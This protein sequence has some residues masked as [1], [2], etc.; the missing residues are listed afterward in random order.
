[1]A[2]E[3][4]APV[5]AEPTANTQIPTRPAE[6]SAEPVVAEAKTLKEDAVIASEGVAEG[7]EHGA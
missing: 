1:M 3:S 7:K 4:T 6:A 5:S 2:D